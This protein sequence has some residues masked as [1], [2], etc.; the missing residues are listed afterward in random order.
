MKVIKHYECHDC[1]FALFSFKHGEIILNVLENCEKVVFG[2]HLENV[3]FYLISSAV[4]KTGDGYLFKGGVAG[5][6]VKRVGGNIVVLVSGA[7]AYG[8][9]WHGAKLRKINSAYRFFVSED[10]LKRA[11][12]NLNLAVAVYY[13]VR[14]VDG[15]AEHVVYFGF[16]LLCLGNGL[17]GSERS[18]K[19]KDANASCRYC[20]D[21]KKCPNC[22]RKSGFVFLE[23]EK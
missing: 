11:V 9:Y 8:A 16:D 2:F 12:H 1:A 7:R 6:L 20:I 15:V 3:G 10:I 22:G 13:G 5:K 17:F 14:V 23:S 4:G 19:I 18:Y 21:R